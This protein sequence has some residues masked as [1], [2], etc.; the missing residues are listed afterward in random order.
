[1]AKLNIKKYQSKNRKNNSYGK[2]YGRVQ[3]GKNDTLDTL[4]VAKH[5]QKHGSIFTQDVIVGVIQRF[6]LC[7]EELLQEGYKVK[8]DGLGTFYLSVRT[9]GEE[10]EEDFNRSNIKRVRIQ[11]LAD[12]S[13]DY[14]CNTQ[15][16][17]TRSAF[18]CADEAESN[19]GSSLN[20]SGSVGSDQT[21][22]V[23]PDV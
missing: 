16:Q 1:M 22:P 5:I 19:S 15:T 14:D 20:S 21:S 11:F 7:I 12:K 6:S 9:E 10:N 18:R 8:L 23:Q 4:D 17:T 3:Y 13:K 2:T